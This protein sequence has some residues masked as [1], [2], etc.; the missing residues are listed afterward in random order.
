MLQDLASRPTTMVAASANILYGCLP[1]H[2]TT[3]ADAVRA[4]VQST[5]KSKNKTYV[6]DLWPGE[7]WKGGYVNPVCVLVRALYGHPEADR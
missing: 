5:L 2:K 6:K 1:G 7:R 3:A 4:Y